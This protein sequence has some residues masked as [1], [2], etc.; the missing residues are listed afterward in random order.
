[1]S[2]IT[3]LAVARPTR[4]SQ[5]ATRDMEGGITCFLSIFYVMGPRL[6]GVVTLLS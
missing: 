1:M 6:L 3:A 5:W 2:S 4:K